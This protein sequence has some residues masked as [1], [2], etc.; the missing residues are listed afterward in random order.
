MVF[1]LCQVSGAVRGSLKRGTDTPGTQTQTQHTSPC[2]HAD[3]WR[4]GRPCP[5]GRKELSPRRPEA[6]PVLAV[7]GGGSRSHVH[8]Y[9]TPRHAGG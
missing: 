8:I 4:G 9:T 1:S 7:W 3:T 6:T 5:L 2:D